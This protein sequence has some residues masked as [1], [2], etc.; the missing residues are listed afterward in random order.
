MLPKIEVAGLAPVALTDIAAEIERRSAASDVKNPNRGRHLILVD[1]TGGS[2][3]STFAKDLVAALNMASRSGVNNEVP[4]SNISNGDGETPGAAALVAVDDISWWLDPIDWESQMLAGVIEP[5]FETGMVN[6][7]PPGWIEKSREGSVTAASN[8]FLVVEGVTAGRVSLAKLATVLIW[9]NTDPEVAFRRMVDRDLALGLNGGTR[10]E[11]E[12]FALDFMAGEIPFQLAQRPWE[13]ADLIVD[14]TDLP[15]TGPMPD[16]EVLGVWRMPDERS[17]PALSAKQQKLWIGTYPSET[18]PIGSGIWEVFIDDAGK[19]GTAQLAA[20][21]P[22]PSFLAIHP[23]GKQ[24]Y[25]VNE[26]E[27]GTVTSFRIDNGQLVYAGNT[28]VNGNSPCHITALPESIWIANYGDGVVTGIAVNPVDG[29]VTSKPHEYVVG[30]V[31]LDLAGADLER[32]TGPHAHYCLPVYGNVLVVDLG[33]D[34]IRSYPPSYNFTESDSGEIVATLPPG[35]GPRHA[36]LLKNN[37]LVVLGELDA[38]IHIL[39]P[40][41]GGWEPF[42]VIPVLPSNYLPKNLRAYPAHITVTDKLL[43]VSI[44]GADVLATYRISYDDGGVPIITP[45]S[46]IPLEQNAWPRHHAVIGTTKGGRLIVVTA[47]QHTDTIMSTLIDPQTG[48]GAPAAQIKIPAAPAC[49]V[50]A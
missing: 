48:Q 32:Q 2:G 36:V 37:Y 39:K 38:K 42:S 29:A 50:A 27:N 12:Q 8:R 30:P 3:K 5:W 4:T 28:Y 25:A 21:T 23:S 24:L 40:K 17:I 1:G 7:R 22:S 9:V 13:R 18:T 33:L 49:V 26:L 31:R 44:R 47:N 11:V 45:L 19:F 34:A 10:A 6:Y 20:E 43:I 46:V 15:R 16:G 35:T 14:C 41:N